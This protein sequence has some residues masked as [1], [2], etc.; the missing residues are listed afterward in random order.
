[1]VLNS[2][3]GTSI[4]MRLFSTSFVPDLVAMSVSGL[5]LLMIVILKALLS[6]Y[7]MDNSTIHKAWN[8]KELF[9]LENAASSRPY[10]LYNMPLFSI[11]NINRGGHPPRAQRVYDQ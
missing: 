7:N 11:T 6:L 5:K 8:A 3:T 10:F 9:V 1:M 2:L 4:D